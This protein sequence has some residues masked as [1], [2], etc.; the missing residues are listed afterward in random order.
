MELII[1]NP[2]LPSKA[3]KT[4]IHFLDADT[5]PTRNDEDISLPLSKN[6]QFYPIALGT[7]FLFT[8]P[9]RYDENDVFFGGTDEEPFLVQ[10][11]SSILQVLK[12]EEFFKGNERALYNALKPKSIAD[13]EIAL[14]KECGRQ[15]DIFFIPSGFSFEELERML[16]AFYPDKYGFDEDGVGGYTE[17]KTGNAMSVFGTRHELHGTAL[18]LS[19][20]GLF[21]EGFLKAPDHAERTLLDVHFMAQTAYLFNPQMAD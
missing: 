8:N 11:N 6:A 14:Q 10:L 2:A 17:A 13:R 12:K 18:I 20:I 3:G 9:R 16:T 21:G 4:K 15:G 19:G 1:P 7:Q 5:H